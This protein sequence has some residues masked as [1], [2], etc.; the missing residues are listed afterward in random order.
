MKDR[1]L[2]FFVDVVRLVLLMV[3]MIEA[4][5]KKDW[6]GVAIHAC[7]IILRCIRLYKYLQLVFKCFKTR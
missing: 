1:S 7:K 3:K 4:F 2:D 5:Q 6:I